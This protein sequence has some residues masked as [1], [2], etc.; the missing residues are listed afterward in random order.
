MRLIHIFFQV[1]QEF[2]SYFGPSSNGDDAPSSSS[3]ISS[4]AG[5]PQAPSATLVTSPSPSTSAA[6]NPAATEAM[7]PSGPS[8]QGIVGLQC[9]P[10][11]FVLG[12][13]ISLLRQQAES[14]NLGQTFLV[15]SVRQ[16]SST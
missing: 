4:P 16:F 6:I 2:E 1:W 14:R 7:S 5:G 10:K 11:K 13:V 3:V 9:W 15:N 12:C 8:L